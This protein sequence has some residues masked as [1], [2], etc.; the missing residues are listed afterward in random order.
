MAAVRAL[1]PVSDSVFVCV[2]LFLNVHRRVAARP[3][4]GP[5][6]TIRVAAVESASM[7]QC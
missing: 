5:E 3:G 1:R 4:R 6:V 7:L 2:C